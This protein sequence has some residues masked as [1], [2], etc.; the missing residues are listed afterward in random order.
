MTTPTR[1]A[2]AHF[3]A[4]MAEASDSGQGK[5]AVARA[6]MAL[7]LETHLRSRPIEDVR[8]ELINMAE[9]LDPDTDYIF[10]RP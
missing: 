4:A 3:A 10:M 1:I 8:K 5:D 6:F 2:R 9:N 7:V